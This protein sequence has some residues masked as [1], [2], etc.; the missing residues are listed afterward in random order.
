[1]QNSNDWM[2]FV[3]KFSS[4]SVMEFLRGVHSHLFSSNLFLRETQRLTVS[5]S[6]STLQHSDSLMAEFMTLSTGSVL[7]AAQQMNE[8]WDTFIDLDEVIC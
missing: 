1:M 8:R 5:V 7:R 4:K 2:F 3:H 6:S